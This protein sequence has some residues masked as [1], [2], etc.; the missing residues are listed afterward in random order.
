MQVYPIAATQ[1][2]VDRQVEHGQIA[3]VMCVS[4]MD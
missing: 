4:E 2:I 3:N 1:L